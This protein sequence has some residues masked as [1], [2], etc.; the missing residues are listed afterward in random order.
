MRV[1]DELALAGCTAPEGS[2]SF[3]QAK[4]R[5]S[6]IEHPAM[7]RQ[8]RKLL[9]NDCCG[10]AFA[11]PVARVY[12]RLPSHLRRSGRNLRRQLYVDTRRRLKRLKCAISGHSLMAS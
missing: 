6:V 5:R 4:E 12:D 1:R 7:Q 11:L 2:L 9:T 3:L 10:P 8:G